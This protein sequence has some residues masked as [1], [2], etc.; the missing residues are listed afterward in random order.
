MT[1]LSTLHQELVATVPHEA[2]ARI[3]TADVAYE[4]D[5]EAM[6]GYVAHDAAVTERKPAVLV[7]H[8]WTG[9]REYPKAR[10]QMLARLG[11]YAFAVDVYGTGRRFDNDEESQAEAGKYYTDMGLLRARVQ[12]AYDVVTADPAVDPDRIVVIGYCFGGTAALEFARTGAP[13]RGT[14]S[15]HGGLVAHEP[16]DVDAI[17]GPLLILTGGADP[18]VPDEAVLAFQN[19]LRTREDLDWQVT[20]Y[21]G[22]PHAFTIPGIP[23][24]RAAA[25][26]RSWRELVAFL[27]EVF[28]PKEDT[29]C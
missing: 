29:S 10:V 12:A 18:I 22:T 20:V 3:V 7:V 23:Y 15:F 13:L 16:A 2:P 19:E 28:A 26:R 25:D 11:Y 8:D 9:L 27:E 5:G 1:K 24:Y 21:S 14:V 6:E 17:T 4:H